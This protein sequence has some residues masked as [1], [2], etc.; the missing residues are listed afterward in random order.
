M[1]SYVQI[2]NPST[3]DGPPAIVVHAAYRRY[4]FNCPEGLQRSLA[5]RGFKLTGKIE[6]VFLTRLDAEA[7]LGLPGLILT[8]ADCGTTELKVHGPA[9]TTHFLTSTRAFVRRVPAGTD[10][11]C[12]PMPNCCASHAAPRKR[13]SRKFAE[14]EALPSTSGDVGLQATNTPSDVSVETVGGTREVEEDAKAAV[15]DF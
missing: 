14:A 11:A 10:F 5:E 2:L 3:G 12:G 8:L 7:C 9:N 6:D 4:L 13:R 1:T 15:Q